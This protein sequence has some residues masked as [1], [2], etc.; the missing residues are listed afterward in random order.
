MKNLPMRSY[1]SRTWLFLFALPMMLALGGC[2]LTGA[3]V[4]A[5]AT[6]GVGLAQERGLK[7]AATDT[8]LSAQILEQYLRA[9]INLPTIIGV[10]VYEARALLTGAVEHQETADKAVKLAW[11]VDGVKEVLNEIQVGQ[12]A[13]IASMAQDSWVSAQLRSKMTFDKDIYAINYTVETVNGVVYL[14]GIAQ[15][16]AEL[17]K[18]KA[19]ASGLQYVRRVVSHVR[20]LDPTKPRP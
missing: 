20:V 1:P 4:G 11:Q 19:H 14:I 12:K 13:G 2:T 17:E 8:A 6:A 18:V 10:E 15:S 5:G 9:D 7:T 3:A 16:P